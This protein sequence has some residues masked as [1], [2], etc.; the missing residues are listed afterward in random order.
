MDGQKMKEPDFRFPPYKHQLREWKRNKDKRAH[1]LLWQMRTGKSRCVID[2][3][4]YWRE[5]YGIDGVL[6]LAPNGV[7]ENWTRR[8]LKKHHWNRVPF[9]SLAFGTEK[10]RTPEWQAKFDK[11]LKSDKLFWFAVNSESMVLPDARAAIKRF[12]KAKKHFFLIAD[13][14]HDF[15]IPGS[16]RTKMVRSISPKLPMGVRILSGT[17]VLNSPLH[18]FSQWELL[19]KEA[20]GFKNFGSF[21]RRYAEIS[22]MPRCRPD[23]SEMYNGRKFPTIIGYKHL[24][25]LRERMGKFASVVLREDCN[26]LPPL[27][28]TVRYVEPT[29]RQLKIYRKLHHE[30]TV[31]INR[32]DVSI[33]E[34]TQ[35]F[36][37]LQQVLSGFLKDEYEVIHRIPGENPRLEALMQELAERDGKFII[38]CQFR[39]DIRI[40]A[41]RLELDGIHFVQYHG[42]VTD[43]EQRQRAID[44]FQNKKSVQ[45]FIGTPAAG[46]QGLDLSA[47][48]HIVNYSHTFNAIHREQSVERAT[49]VGGRSITVTDLIVPNSI[50]EYIR[51]KVREKVSRSQA[52]AGKGM[53]DMLEGTIL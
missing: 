40:V 4:C 47:A 14:C 5:E 25:E 31:S 37:K 15:R 28:E 18:A 23:G 32:E 52:L 50:E 24:E 36:I 2:L 27:I 11:Y 9:N 33:G 7:H 45:G 12:I 35:R 39:E 51:R 49:A 43:K 3:G 13:E 38:W 16:K 34:N 8:E 44:A 6:I 29:K 42:G 30:Y 48:H 22:F 20:L 41:E 17:A 26:D 46:G 10:S 1:A 53:R 19:K 21:K